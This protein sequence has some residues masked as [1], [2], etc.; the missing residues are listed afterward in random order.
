MNEDICNNMYHYSYGWK[1]DATPNVQDW[2]FYRISEFRWPAKRGWN[3]P[4]TM[5][6]MNGGPNSDPN[7]YDL[8]DRHW[9]NWWQNDASGWTFGRDPERHGDRGNY[10]F[11][12]GHVRTMKYDISGLAFWD[13]RE[14][15]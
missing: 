5:W 6:H 13:P 15:Q 11:V 7:S 8:S 4:S 1:Q 14:V 9:P 3:G 10:L 12:D 2:R